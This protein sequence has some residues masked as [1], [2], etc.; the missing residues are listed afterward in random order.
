METIFEGLDGQ[1][2]GNKVK[3]KISGVGLAWIVVYDS[4]GSLLKCVSISEE[5]L[6]KISYAMILNDIEEETKK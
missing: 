5:V 6:R 4:E 3:V 1:G 2:F